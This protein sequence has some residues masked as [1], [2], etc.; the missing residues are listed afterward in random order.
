MYLS[1]I[2]LI[3]LKGAGGLEYTDTPGR[4]QRVLHS[5]SPNAQDSPFQVPPDKISQLPGMTAKTKTSAVKS[6]AGKSIVVRRLKIGIVSS[7]FGVH[8]VST[9]IRGFVQVNKYM[10]V[11]YPF[12]SFFIIFL[13]LFL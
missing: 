13:S 11:F 3:C 8:P 5:R 10:T 9:L 12:F 7:D 1:L 6:I 4:A 2:Y